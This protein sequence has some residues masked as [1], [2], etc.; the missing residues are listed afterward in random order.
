[1]TATAARRAQALVTPR[2]AVTLHYAALTAVVLVG[3]WLRLTALK[4]QSLWFD[5]IDVVVRA[6]RPFGVVLRTFVTAGENGPLYN[7]FLALWIRVAGISEIAVRF[8]S[9]V[10]GV[11]AIPVLYVLVRR[12]SDATTALFAAGLLAI[13]PYHVWYSQEA[14][15]YAILVLEAL[16]S[17]LLLVEALDRN[18][19]RWWVGYALVTTLMF[20][21]HV[22]SVLVF[23]GQSLYVVATRRAW[24]GRERGWLLAAAALTLPY[25]PIALW[26]LRVVSG[27]V[28]TWQPAVGLWDAL[29]ILGIKFAVNRSTPDIQRRAALLYAALA[30]GGVAAL[31]WPRRPRRWWL[32]LAAGAATPVVGLYLV[33]L[34]QSVFADR[35]A[36]VALPPYIA[37]VAAAT[38]TLTRSRRAWPLGL[39]VMVALLAC[40]W[41]PLRDVNRSSAAQKEDWRSAYAYVA[42][43]GQPGDV[44][45][46]EPNYLI[47]TLTYYAQREPRLTAYP[48]VTIP[49]FRVQWLT[50]PLM[51]KMIR[52]QAPRATRF[53]LVQ[54]PDRVPA[55]DP[56]HTLEGWLASNGPPHDDFEVNGVRVSLYVLPAP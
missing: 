1:M 50:E 44:I 16:L 12:V 45:V 53:W 18:R 7:L 55:D 4:R 21:T 32:L 35:Y 10:A 15:M 56:N 46:I 34:R 37:L 41:T 51:I 27:G 31:A 48:A 40:A 8:P 14:K 19:P 20:Y 52:D 30:L 17:T 9:A 13:S 38:A 26:A 36:I 24:R 33:S 49:S 6:Q 11:L 25:V 5:E 47:T 3:A 23:V 22:A 54:S 29:R 2:L 43:R 28:T 42:D 39:A